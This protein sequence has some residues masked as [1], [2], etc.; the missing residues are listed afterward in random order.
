[1]ASIRAQLNGT[2]TGFRYQG[3]VEAAQFCAQNK[4]NLPEALQWADSAIS[5]PFFGRENFATLQAKAQVLM[6]MGRDADAD[7]VMQKAI[8][9]PTASNVDAY[10]YGRGLLNAGKTEKAMEIFRLNQKLHPEDKFTQQRRTGQRVHRIG[11]QKECNQI[12]GVGDQECSSRIRRQYLPYYEG[13]LK[14]L[15]GGA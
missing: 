13:E 4:I 15:K 2:T 14:K 7:A 10:Q 3:Y 5:Q 6:A 9:H 1:M 8:K 11:R 12:L